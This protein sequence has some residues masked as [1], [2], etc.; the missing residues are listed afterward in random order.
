[1]FM[2][3]FITCALYVNQNRPVCN[4]FLFVRNIGMAIYQVPALW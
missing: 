4:I 1:M 2:Q 3:V